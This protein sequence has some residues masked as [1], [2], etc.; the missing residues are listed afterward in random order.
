MSYRS[1]VQNTKAFL[2][3]VV[4]LVG[5]EYFSIRDPDSGLT[6]KP[7]FR[8]LVGALSLPPAVNDPR[9]VSTTIAAASFT[10]LDKNLAVTNMVGDAALALISTEV[11]IFIGRCGVS[12]DFSQYFPLPVMQLR[13]MSKPDDRY[14]FSVSQSTDQINRAI[15]QAATR[16]AG[17]IFPDT[18]AFFV[19]DDISSFP[20]TGL[21]LVGNELMS[22]AAKDDT[23]REFSGLFRGLYGTTAIAYADD[24]AVSLADYVEDNPLNI[25]L[26]ILTSSGGGGA[27]DNLS[28]GVALDVSLV[29]VT[30]IEAVRD[31][32]FS[33]VTFRHVLS[34]ISNA[35]TEIE[36]EFL[37]PNNLR[38]SYSENS[39]LTIVALNKPEFVEE[40]DITTHDTLTKLP[41]WTIDGYK[42]TN[43][44]QLS[45]DYD[46]STGIFGTIQTYRDAASIALY[47][48]Q[49]PL[50]FSWKGVRRDIGGLAIVTRFLDQYFSRL[51]IPSPEITVATQLDKSLL[52][53]GDKTIL[54]TTKIP[55]KFGQLKFDAELEIA[56]AGINWQAGEVTQKLLFTSF[57]GVRNCYL[58]PSDTFLSVQAQNQVTL[59][60]GRGDLWQRFWAVRLWDKVAGDY[61]GDPVN[62]I[63]SISGDVITFVNNWATTITTNHRLKFPDF[64]DAVDSQRRYCFINRAGFDFSTGQESYKITP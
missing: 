17:D 63:A 29:D 26:R 6:I 7:E 27:Y 25:I 4:I 46:Y 57:T 14:T 23:L 59:G 9:R 13:Q 34:K 28:D 15:Y 36:D 33:A 3:N 54:R 22:Y 16:V 60:A 48:V 37:F 58:A 40:A 32:Y 64:D 47:G 39:K 20:A 55:N 61:T 11:R 62:F 18:S 41:Q 30:A 1:E 53:P 31:Q 5:G 43:Q 10:L 12:M 2:A 21:L 38:F 52:N 50:T 42:I 24:V 19:K 56:S 49:N 45:W 8:G 44:I 35:L 51:A